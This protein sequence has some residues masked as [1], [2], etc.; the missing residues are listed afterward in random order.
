MIKL[1]CSLLLFFGSRARP[2]YAHQYKLRLFER[3]AQVLQVLTCTDVLQ[4]LE[5][6]QSTKVSFCCVA[7]QL[8]CWQGSAEGL[9]V[10]HTVS[11][12][13]DACISWVGARAYLGLR[14]FPPSTGNFWQL[15][16]SLEETLTQHVRP[17]HTDG[18]LMS[19]L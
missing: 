8:L 17:T 19:L 1:F 9:P 7:G 12:A 2:T 11:R 3:R 4:T 10:K 6:K 18:L 13:Q 5:K 14:G 15:T 16:A